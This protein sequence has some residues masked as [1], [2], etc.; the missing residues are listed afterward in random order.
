MEKRIQNAGGLRRIAVTGPESTG[1]SMLCAQLAAHYGT[2]HV[3]E[4]SR[5][6]LEKLG[7]PYQLEDIL[8][9]ARGQLALE[10]SIA[11][12][13]SGLL[14]CD[15]EFIVTRIWSLFKY[16]TCDPWIEQQIEEH[17]Y[18]LYLLCDIDLPWEPDALREHPQHRQRLFDMYLGELKQRNLPFEVIIGSGKK[19][20]QAAIKIIERHFG[21]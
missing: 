3:P 18:D 13:S 16:H 6:Y 2:S 9:I 7:K 8:H 12:K 4:F 11:S 1:K 14:F 15:T 20:L 21:K 5:I 10:D 17:R 19:R